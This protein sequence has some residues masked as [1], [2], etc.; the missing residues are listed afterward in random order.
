MIDES[1]GMIEESA[2]KDG[3]MIISAISMNNHTHTHTQDS[4]WWKIEYLY[5]I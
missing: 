1:L 2:T 3:N 4:L 5:I